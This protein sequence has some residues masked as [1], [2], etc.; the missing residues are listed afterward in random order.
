MSTTS[1]LLRANLRSHARRYIATGLAI[2]VSLIFVT[3][4]TNFAFGM[5]ASINQQILSRISGANLVITN[6]N[7][8]KLTQA[9]TTLTALPDVKTV[10][11][12]Q[13]AWI[14]ITK[15]NTR[16]SQPLSTLLPEPFIQERVDEGRAPTG[17]SD[18]MLT[19]TA[20][21]QLG[22]TIGDTVNITTFGE[23]HT[24]QEFH[25][26]GITNSIFIGSTDSFV[27]AQ[28]LEHH[29]IPS[30]P[31]MLLVAANSETASS[32]T[33]N[34]TNQTLKTH[35][36]EALKTV[37]ESDTFQVETYEESAESLRKE[38]GNAFASILVGVLVFPAIAAVVA[39]IIVHS[40]FQV[41]LHQRKREMGLLRAIGA[42][43]RQLRRIILAETASVGALASAFALLVGSALSLAAFYATGMTPT[44]L[45][46]AHML[47]APAAALIFLTGTLAT[48]LV[49]SRPAFTAARVSP[50]S[51]LSP[52]EDS[53][54]RT[55]RLPVFRLGASSV[56][57]MAC[58]A[59]IYVYAGHESN[60]TRFGVL[61]ALSLLSLLAVLVLLS[62]LLP[63]LTRGLGRLAPSALGQMARQNTARNPGRTSATGI[64]IIIGVTLMVTMMVGAASMR[65]TLS[66]ELDNRRPL[67]FEVILEK[68]ANPDSIETEIR[69]LDH[70]SATIQAQFVYT[71]IPGLG[72]VSIGGQPD[73][74]PVLH[75]EKPLLQPGQMA[76][77]DEGLRNA[78]PVG[79]VISAPKAGTSFTVTDQR[80]YLSMPVVV[81]AAQL[82]EFDGPRQTQILVKIDDPMQANAVSSKIESIEG[83]EFAAGSAIERQTYTEMISQVLNVVL[84]L[85]GVSVAVSLIGV[86]NTLNLS[87]RERTR[88]NGLLRALGL[89]RRQMRHLLTLEALLIA[90]SATGIGVGLGVFYA[91]V[92]MF[93]LPL[94]IAE[95]HMSAPWWQLCAVVAVAVLSAIVA[96]VSPGRKA[97]RVTPVEALQTI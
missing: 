11:L 41:I 47:S 51:A 72:D 38:A 56:V 63:Y 25:V 46:G 64:A 53:P 31:W 15:D 20:A 95:I 58:L 94:Q 82:D 62:V 97:S 34:T 65:T 57:L 50:M 2:A 39:L 40:T 23:G 80:A 68:D 77:Q 12:P 75:H 21:Q 78:T 26:V 76:I 18:I 59:G 42:R 7:S 32:A 37:E 92:G 19:N 36:Q 44:L 83:V 10:A 73:I 33:T 87:V 85:V 24:P 29:H 66:T 3:L 93:A 8:D 74:N 43:T 45:E 1:H 89:T 55:R 61:V 52:V 9:A 70:V 69:A 71:H 17:D 60:G 91:W 90:V 16:I 30:S 35:V 79:T 48:I 4:A 84:A 28:A 5:N 49:G 14:Q 54:L 81:P 13:R 27:T 6:E 67:D 96:S 88:E 22:A 86:S